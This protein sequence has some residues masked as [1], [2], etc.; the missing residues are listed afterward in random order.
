VHWNIEVPE[1]LQANRRET[2]IGIFKFAKTV[3]MNNLKLKY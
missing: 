3:L 2:L 1:I